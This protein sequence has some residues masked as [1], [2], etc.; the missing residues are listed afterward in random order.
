M[1]SLQQSVRLDPNNMMASKLLFKLQGYSASKEFIASIA[2]EKQ[3]KEI[4]SFK[5]K[6]C[7]YHLC[8]YHPFLI[9]Y[10]QIQDNTFHKVSPSLAVSICRCMR[11]RG[12]LSTSFSI[13]QAILQKGHLDRE[14]VIEYTLVLYQKN[15]R[16]LLYSFI[17]S[18]PSSLSHQSEY[19]Y[20]LGVYSLLT[21]DFFTALQH[22][23]LV[24]ER[25][26]CF[27]EAW[28]GIGLTRSMMVL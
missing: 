27:W 20:M 10:Q 24:L 14:I 6:Y 25:D 18:Y 4:R 3:S 12:D 1:S 11:E 21:H 19:G 8:M 28:I 26:P 15:M 13:L 2:S 7:T 16:D 22:F 9:P 5:K 23:N 17:H